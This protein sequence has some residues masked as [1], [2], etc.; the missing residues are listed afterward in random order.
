MALTA[1]TKEQHKGAG[2][3]THRG[4]GQ[5]ARHEPFRM[6]RRT[7]ERLV[8]LAFLL[9]ALAY[10]ALFF[11]YPIYQDISLS[12]QNY[13]FSAL[14][15]GHGTYV[16]LSNYRTMLDSSV[17]IHALVNTLEFTVLSVVCQFSIGFGMAMY[18]NMK[19]TGSGF[20]RRLILVPWVMPLVVTGT[21]FELVFSTSNG[22]ANELLRTAGLIHS[23]IGW[24]TNGQLAVLAIIAANIWAGVPFN[25]VLL[26]SGLQDVPG[27]Q[28]EAASVDGA[29]AWQ[30]FRRV[31]VPTMRP[32]ILIVLMLGVV[33]TAKAFDIVIVLTNGGP[34]N[35]S[36]LM[37]SWAYTQAFSL[38]QFGTGTAVGNIL[39][40]FSFLVGI[41]YIRLSRAEAGTGGARR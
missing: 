33:Y 39:L 13:G 28:L 25:A 37:S 26:Y 29:N 20:L 31:T 22:L 16:G 27:E 30:R 10:V 36:Q 11:G 35:E 34:A 32:V 14:A 38:F 41:V 12:L 24:L 1:T 4:L 7:S 2:L 18:L 40:L 19:F 8:L 9:P 5:T 6:S 17:T 23:P 15:A 21:I 3:T